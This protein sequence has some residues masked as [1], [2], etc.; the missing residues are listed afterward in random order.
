ML[1]LTTIFWPIAI[2]MS[3]LEMISKK[4]LE[5]SKIIPL[6]FAIFALSISYYL[7][8]LHKHGF[9]YFNFSCPYTL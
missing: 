9:C 4:N 2:P 6:I 5:F 1:L 8:Y 3:F 7:T